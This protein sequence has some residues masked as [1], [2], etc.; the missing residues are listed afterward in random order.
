MLFKLT[1]TRLTMFIVYHSQ[2]DG[3]TKRLNKILKKILCTYIGYKENNWDEYLIMAEFTYNNT[4]QMSL[5]FILFELNCK[6]TP[7]TPMQL[8]A[9]NNVIKPDEIENIS[10]KNEFIQQ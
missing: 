3:Q 9:I 10:M 6:Q 4:K 1:D 7:V 8:A 5:E 2:T